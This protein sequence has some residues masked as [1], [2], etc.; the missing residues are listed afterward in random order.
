MKRVNCILNNHKYK[1]YINKNSICEEERIFCKH[2]LE[3]FLDVSRIAYIM[4]LE[5]GVD[6]SKE[7]IYAIGLL[8]DIGRWVEYQG[9]E[10]H[11]KASFRLSEE[12]LDECGF[13]NEEKEIILQGILNHR[14]KE[15]T[16]LNKIIYLAD[17][18]SRACFLC[19]AE[20]LCKWS[21]EKK[22]LNII[23]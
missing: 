23:I 5:E 14:N 11:E 16:G 10:S 7:I 4:A 1:D 12:I 22:N 20:S 9:G 15:A 13:N 17:K 19:K 6:A 2:N 8:H 18:R 21:K 3:H